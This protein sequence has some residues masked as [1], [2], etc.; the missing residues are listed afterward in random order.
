[1]RDGEMLDMLIRA[2]HA[3]EEGL[4][5]DSS[6]DS[7][8]T[9]DV[10]YEPPRVERLWREFEDGRLYL[11]RIH[12]C[13]K[14]LY[15]PHPWPSAIK[16]LSGSYMMALGYGKM[17]MGYGRMQDVLRDGDS[18]QVP[19]PCAAT[20]VL[21][22]GSTYEMIRPNGWHSVRPLGGTSYSIMVTGPKWDGV[23]SP[24]ADHKLGPLSP[25]A[26]R[27]IFDSFRYASFGR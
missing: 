9:L 27:I 10:N 6:F 26:K 8:R 4:L 25:Q 20:L 24:K 12:P 2:E 17:Q 18:F 5:D 3:L 16:I 14:A 19:P 13:E 23:W 22:K 11:H 15:H 1:M 21:T 7:W